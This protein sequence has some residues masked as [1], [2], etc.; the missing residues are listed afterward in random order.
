MLDTL[1]PSVVSGPPRPSRIVTP[2]SLIRHPGHERYVVPGGGAL[3]VQLATGDRLTLIN[4]EGGQ[5]VELVAAARDGR[6][7]AALL[8][9]VANAT[10]EGL[11]LI[12]I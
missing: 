11:S 8:G 6:I 9:Q 5:P 1:Y 7:D 3:L 10:A 2:A 4:D 12:H